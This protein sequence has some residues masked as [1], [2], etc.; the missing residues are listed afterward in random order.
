M[1]P[2]AYKELSCDLIVDLG[3]PDQFRTIIT[4]ISDRKGIQYDFKNVEGKFFCSFIVF[5]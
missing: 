1:Q 4:F 5:L 3:I 2:M